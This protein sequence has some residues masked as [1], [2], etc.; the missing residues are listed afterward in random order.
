MRAALSSTAIPSGRIPAETL[1]V[2]RACPSTEDGGGVVTG[3]AAGEAGRGAAVTGAV[4][5]AGLAHRKNPPITTRPAARTA[6]ASG[7]AARPVCS[8]APALVI[9]GLTATAGSALRVTAGSGAERAG[10]AAG[11]PVDGTALGAASAR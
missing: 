1:A 7:R 3:D 10:G 8:G 6:S 2:T 11:A 9:S 5:S 4:G